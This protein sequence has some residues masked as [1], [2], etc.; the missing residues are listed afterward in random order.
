MEQFAV[1]EVERGVSLVSK[2]V[3]GRNQSSM[4]KVNDQKHQIT[5]KLTRG[6]I[7]N[8]IF[9][10]PNIFHFDLPSFEDALLFVVTDTD[11]FKAL[12]FHIHLPASTLPCGLSCS[13]TGSDSIW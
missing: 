1:V 2:S 11:N 10:V 3:P 13:L 9:V 12:T 5:Q 7:L 4:L 6:Q 8:I